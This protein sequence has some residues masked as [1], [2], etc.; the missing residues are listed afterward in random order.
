MIRTIL[1]AITGA[2]AVLAMAMGPVSAH[3]FD[4]AVIAPYSGSEASNGKAFWQGMRVATRERDS[5]PAETSDGHLGGLDSNLLK[6]DSA[7]TPPALQAR[8]KELLGSGE[9][10]IAVVAPAARAAWSAASLPAPAVL[11]APG[12]TPLNGALR[13]PPQPPAAFAILYRADYGQPPPPAAHHGYATARLI[14]RALRPLDGEMS[15]KA[16]L[17]KSFRKAA[18]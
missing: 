14:E 12:D 9:I 8:I 18:R 2:L 4:I 15:D 7:A 5:H 1:T 6:V 16:R 3:S 17:A 13:P 10:D 11:I